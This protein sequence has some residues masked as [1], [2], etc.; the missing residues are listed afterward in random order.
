MNYLDEDA[1]AEA[2][3]ALPWTDP[4]NVVLIMQPEDGPTKVYQPKDPTP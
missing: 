4:E 3:L 2:F 1:F